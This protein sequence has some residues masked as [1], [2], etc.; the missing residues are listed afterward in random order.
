M[1]TQITMENDTVKIIQL[2]A[3]DAYRL[4]HLVQKEAVHSCIY[5]DY[6]AEMARHIFTDLQ[7]Q[8]GGKFFQCAA[9]TSQE[10]K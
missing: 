1:I 6:W 8:A 5:N 2:P 9:C 10:E 4:L 3:E 7:A